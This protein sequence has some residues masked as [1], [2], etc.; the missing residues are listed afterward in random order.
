MFEFMNMNMTFFHG[1]GMLIFWGFIIFLI[2]VIFNSKESTNDKEKETA[3]DILEKRFA[4][5]EISENEYK[6]KKEVLKEQE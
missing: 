4:K 5:G 3:L 1:F 6:S 2:F